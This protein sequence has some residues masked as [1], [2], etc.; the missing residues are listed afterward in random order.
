MNG[1]TPQNLLKILDKHFDSVAL[2]E[3]AREMGTNYENLVGDTK[4]GRF[5]SLIE[6]AEQ[7]N[8]VDRLLELVV[9][10]RPFLRQE[11][12]LVQMKK[13]SVE[14]IKWVALVLGLI[15]AIITIIQFW[16]PPDPPAPADSQDRILLQVQVS[17]SENQ[18]A[19]ANARVSLDVANQLFSPQQTDSTGR[20]VFELPATVA[21]DIARITVEVNGQVQTQTITVDFGMRAVEFQI[22]P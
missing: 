1:R 12:G 6:H 7:H 11:L 19:I 18:L 22:R 14:T 4:R 9:E 15:A 5:L 3:L 16:P 21:K 17:N 10:K 8:Q 13:I 20:A 2:R